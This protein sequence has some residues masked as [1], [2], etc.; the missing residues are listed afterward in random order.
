MLEHYERPEAHAHIDWSEYGEL[1]WNGDERWDQITETPVVWA[2]VS[3][4]GGVLAD[5]GGDTW[6]EGVT[7]RDCG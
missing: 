7:W 1:V 3:G 4:M 2:L 5:D 6:R